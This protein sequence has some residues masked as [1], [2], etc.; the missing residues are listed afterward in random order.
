MLDGATNVGKLFA[1][2]TEKENAFRE[3]RPDFSAAPDAKML[4]VPAALVRSSIAA[5]W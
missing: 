2:R 1:H 4:S 3:S 5:G